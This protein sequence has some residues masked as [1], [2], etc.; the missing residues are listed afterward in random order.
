MV[1]CAEKTA[2]SRDNKTTGRAYTW[3]KLASGS[4]VSIG[5]LRTQDNTGFCSCIV[6]IIL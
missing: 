1:N 5:A 6:I 2:N 3:T 4:A